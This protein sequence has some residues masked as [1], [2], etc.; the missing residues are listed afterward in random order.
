MRGGRRR[1]TSQ[2]SKPTKIGVLLPSSVA[3]AAEV[4]RMEVL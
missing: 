4:R 2:V 3:F 1:K